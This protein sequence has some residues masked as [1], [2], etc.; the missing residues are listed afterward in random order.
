MRSKC[1]TPQVDLQDM[2]KLL[3]QEHR[4]SEMKQCEPQNTRNIKGR[5]YL[6]KE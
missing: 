6:N 1:K 5:Q 3:Q 4:S 2:Y